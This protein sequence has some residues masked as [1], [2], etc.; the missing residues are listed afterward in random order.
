M[1]VASVRMT[2]EENGLIR[3]YCSVHGISVS[4][5]MKRALLERIEDEL[6]LIAYEEAEKKYLENP[7]TVPWDEVK[8]KIGL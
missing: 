2:E 4:E 1:P 8:K 6:D 5:A 7:T 3:G